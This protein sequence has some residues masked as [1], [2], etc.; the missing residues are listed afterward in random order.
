MEGFDIVTYTAITAICYLIGLGI[1]TSKLPDTIIPV[2]VGTCGAGLGIACYFGIPNFSATVID[3]IAI[4]VVSGL[5][6][7]GVNQLYKQ[8]GKPDASQYTVVEETPEDPVNLDSGIKI[9]DIDP[10]RDDLGGG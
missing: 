3:A 7:T 9:D 1:K 6:S 8:L 4:G 10:T 2:V 5:A